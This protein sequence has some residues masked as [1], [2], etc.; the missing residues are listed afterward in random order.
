LQARDGCFQLVAQKEQFCPF[1]LFV[2]LT[3][4]KSPNL[5]DSD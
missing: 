2:N 5:A 4:N 1:R 3:T